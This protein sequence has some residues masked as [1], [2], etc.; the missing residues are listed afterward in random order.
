MNVMA[1]EQE[2]PEFSYATLF[3]QQQP[4]ILLKGNVTNSSSSNS[5]PLNFCHLE[6]P[7]TWNPV[8]PLPPPPLLCDIVK[9]CNSLILTS[10][11][12]ELS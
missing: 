11:S 8:P 4:T 2:E 7:D 9:M 10:K 1:S 3:L 5:T 12:L 6:H